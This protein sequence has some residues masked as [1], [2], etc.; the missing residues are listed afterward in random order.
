LFRADTFALNA[1][2]SREGEDAPRR[3]NN[4]DIRPD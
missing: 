2:T 3:K 1:A 4:S